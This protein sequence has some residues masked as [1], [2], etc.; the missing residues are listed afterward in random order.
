[1][2][3]KIPNTF[4]TRGFEEMRNQGRYTAKRDVNRLPMEALARAGIEMTLFMM[5][6][7]SVTPHLSMNDRERIIALPRNHVVNKP[8]AGD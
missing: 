7:W 3:M 4:G 6:N 1:M 2:D 5:N 8:S